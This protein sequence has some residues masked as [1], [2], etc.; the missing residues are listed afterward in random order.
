MV[1]SSQRTLYMCD[2]DLHRQLG[3]PYTPLVNTTLNE[4]FSVLINE[5]IPTDTYP[6]LVGYVIGIGGTVNIEGYEGY[7]FNEHSPVDGALFEHIPFVMREVTADLSDEERSK[8]RLRTIETINNTQY[9]CYYMRVIPSFEL[10]P[11]F[12]SIKTVMNS[13]SVSSPTLS[14]FDTNASAILNPKPRN[15]SVDYKTSNTAEYVTKIAKVD[16]I[17]NEIEQVEINNCLKIKGKDQNIITEIGLCTGIDIEDQSGC[18]ETLATQVAYHIAVNFS[19]ATELVGGGNI[20]K[21]IELGGLEPF[22]M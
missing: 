10:K 1:R 18:L 19:L 6:K 14:I 20:N 2:I 12:Y 8:Y 16:F 21:A 22:I 3:V 13:T 4:K 5:D 17:L 15:R 7:T 11:T 9:A